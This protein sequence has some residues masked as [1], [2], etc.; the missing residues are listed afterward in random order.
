[1]FNQYP[2]LNIQDL[3]LDYIIKAIK[4]MRYEVT[5]FV[6]INAIKYANPIQWNITTQ[7]EKNTIV[8]DPV[9]GT[10]YI[11][12]APVPA[13]VALTRPEYWT[14]VFDL[15]SFVTRAAQN[16]TSRWES[17]TTLTATFPTNT[18][19]WLVWGDVLY[20]ALSNIIAGDTYV[21]GSNI[22][23]F[24]IEDLYNT[25]LNTIAAILAIIGDLTDLTT[26]DTTSIVNAI[27]SVVS[28]LGN[29][30]NLP[31][32]DK[33]SIV[34][35][36]IEIDNN[37]D[38][39]DARLSIIEDSEP[40]NVLTLGIDNT[41]AIDC[42][43]AIN[44]ALAT[45]ALYFP[46]GRYKITK[47]IVASHNI[48]GA[49]NSHGST[50][51]TH[52][53]PART[54]FVCDSTFT[55]NAAIECNSDNSVMLKDFDI[56]LH[57]N[58]HGIDIKP[59]TESTFN[60]I[61][62]VTII[63][64]DSYGVY[65]DP[66]PNISKPVYINECA[67]FGKEYSTSNGIYLGSNAPDCII[68][69]TWIMG[70]QRGLYNESNLVIMSD[71]HIWCG[72]YSFVDYN[73]WWSGTIGIESDGHVTATNLYIDSPLVAFKGDNTGDFHISNLVMWFDNSMAGSAR[74]DASLTYLFDSGRVTID[75]GYIRVTDRMKYMFNNKRLVANNVGVVLDD[76]VTLNASNAY[77]FPVLKEND[78]MYLPST[79][80]VN[81]YHEICCA[82]IPQFGTFQI[83]VNS[84]YNN[85]T[86]FTVRYDLGGIAVFQYDESATENYYYSFSGG[87]FK[88]YRYN[89]DIYT[90]VMVKL[91][92]CSENINV[93][94][95][96]LARYT[97]NNDYA[98]DFK[99]DTS[100]LTTITP[101]QVCRTDWVQF[102]DTITI[103]ADSSVV[104]TL[105]IV[106]GT[107]YGFVTGIATQVTTNTN[108][109]FECT[110]YLGGVL[111][112]QIRNNSTNAETGAVT[113]YVSF[114]TNN[115]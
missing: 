77:V 73:D 53:N 89:M 30:N 37:V 35:S 61:D 91:I 68:S 23:H 81:L 4:E 113:V 21:V 45:N 103:P 50:L 72:P 66:T 99:A 94:N 112:A 70:I 39:I 96:N 3:N 19:E 56:Y 33:T 2:Y 93:I 82:Y 65:V 104:V 59:T 5:N 51:P 92:S 11:S 28:D 63:N 90:G 17:D 8:I 60:K 84:S 58:E 32:V 52:N 54:L 34:N 29:L 20:K 111:T 74:Y 109:A 75:N 79:D 80:G 14:V 98:R 71:C 76:N 15:G 88:L 6:S 47:P 62:R 42:A 102:G 108:F 114:L 49:G 18:G 107:P 44:V 24:T 57:G 69:R 16:F 7:Y 41:G 25:Y 36:I 106:N 1:M 101:S 43:D 105:P 55:G 27:N 97:N 110:T 26:S 115:I 78:T 22:E 48:Y 46:M 87:I 67:I 100:G 83:V 86:K 40:I 38:A 64:V 12:V 95:Y 9:T 85:V 13:G 10:A 31:T